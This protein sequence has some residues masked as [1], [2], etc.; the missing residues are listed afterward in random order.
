MSRVLIVF[1]TTHGQTARIAQWMAATL[2]RDGAEADVVNARDAAGFNPAAYD[3]VIVAASI[4]A[5][6]YQRPV[7]RWIRRNLAELRRRPGAFISV[8][9]GVIE[10]RAA[11]QHELGRI[12]RR[13]L[14]GCG[15]EPVMQRHVAGALPYT[16]YGWLTRR[17]MRRIVARAGGDTDTSRDYEYTDWDEIERLAR[18]F[19]SGLKEPSSPLGPVFTATAV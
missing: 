4:N 8:C 13:F 3:G 7:R 5:G 2:R 11:T 9:L 16:R 1:G 12:M 10:E 17:I 18:Q 14:D 6:G 19:H 15:W